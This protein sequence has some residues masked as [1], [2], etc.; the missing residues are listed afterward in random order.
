MF[1]E[2]GTS[3]FSHPLRLVMCCETTYRS[4][5]GKYTFSVWCW[6]SRVFNPT[7]IPILYGMLQRRV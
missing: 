6:V 7:Y 1:I 2:N 4:Y 3:K 5:E